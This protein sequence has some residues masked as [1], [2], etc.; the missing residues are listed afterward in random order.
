MGALDI[1]YIAE[2]P[3][4]HVTNDYLVFKENGYNISA[5]LNLHWNTYSHLQGLHKGDVDIINLYADSPIYRI[6]IYPQLMFEIANY[7]KDIILKIIKEY[8]VDIIY[9]SW[10]TA[11][12]PFIK[13]LKR[14]NIKI[15]IVIRFLMYPAALVEPVIK[16]ENFYVRDVVKNL[17]GRIYESHRMKR[18]MQKAFNFSGTLDNDLVFME[19]FSKRYFFKKRLQKLSDIDGEPHIVFLGST[20]F[21]VRHNDIST[22]IRDLTKHHVHIHMMESRY[23]SFK[24]K[25]YVHYFKPFSHSEI[26]EGKLGTF[27]T[28]FD[29]ALVTYNPQYRSIDRFKNVFPNRFKFSLFGGIPIILPDGVLSSCEELIRRYKIGFT[30]NTV[31]DLI[32]KLNNES[33]MKLIRKNAIRSHKFMMYERNF[34]VL[35]KFLRNIVG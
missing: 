7:K 34:Q 26:L 17:E 20:N 35:D 13:V 28:Q 9:A 11:V 21:G 31:G 29:A 6:Y 25:K 5:I 32:S 19:Y 27:L 1:L 12:I 3:A 8:N 23:V 16:I 24:D 22:L 4:F 10:S 14:L 15:P 30:Y 2:L 18:Y 33:L